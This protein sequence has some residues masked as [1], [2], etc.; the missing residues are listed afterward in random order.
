MTYDLLGCRWNARLSYHPS[1]TLG[2]P[3][4]EM[5]CG[6]A[7]HS[8]IASASFTSEV[9]SMRNSIIG[10]LLSSSALLSIAGEAVGHELFLKLDSYYV[11]PNF[12][13][14]LTLLNG[15]FEESAGP[16]ARNRMRDVSISGPSGTTHPDPEGWVDADKQ[17]HLTITI[18]AEGGHVADVSTQY[19]VSEQS[20][21][22]FA[23]YLKL[24]GIPDLLAKYD[25]SA[26]PKR[27][28][29]SLRKA[30]AS[31]VPSRGG[32]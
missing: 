12:K 1:S 32:V 19:A 30:R 16:V 27:R 17:T 21:E 4:E 29:I 31:D 9:Q 23:D 25:K 24:E 3:A 26:Y 10:A 2:L 15:T 7:G 13:T 14:T 22:G 8:R 28:P 20:A 11:Q 5:F 18:G 6:R